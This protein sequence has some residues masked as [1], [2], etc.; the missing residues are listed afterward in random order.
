MPLSS[1][2]PHRNPLVSHSDTLN[3]KSSEFPFH[4]HPEGGGLDVQKAREGDEKVTAKV[5]STPPG[6]WGGERVSSDGGSWGRGRRDQPQVDEERERRLPSGVYLDWNCNIRAPA[7]VIAFRCLAVRVLLNVPPLWLSDR[8]T[9]TSPRSSRSLR[10]NGAMD[11]SVCLILLYGIWLQDMYNVIYM[12]PPSEWVGGV[13]WLWWTEHH[14]TTGGSDRCGS[15]RHPRLPPR[16]SSVSRRAVNGVILSPLHPR[17]VSH[18]KMT[19]GEACGVWFLSLQV[20]NSGNW[21]LYWFSASVCL[22]MAHLNHAGIAWGLKSV[23]HG[24]KLVNRF[25]FPLFSFYFTCVI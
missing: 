2:L 19:D 9:V 17:W 24:L 12:N 8:R 15:L 25:P 14:C 4:T 10:G 3:I 7:D 23:G 5:G 13:L 6:S 22:Q 21:L 20:Y 1:P 18:T 11:R 16:L